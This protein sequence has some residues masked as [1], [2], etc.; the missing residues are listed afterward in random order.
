MY[1]EKHSNSNFRD[2]N[3]IYT[4]IRNGS[5]TPNFFPRSNTIDT[6]RTVSQSFD[7]SYSNS[8]AGGDNSGNFGEGAT[9][10]LD[11]T[12]FLLTFIYNDYSNNREDG[13]ACLGCDKSNSSSDFLLQLKDVGWATNNQYTI[14]VIQG[15]GLLANIT[16]IM[17][18]SYF[19]VT[20]P[21][22]VDIYTKERKLIRINPPSPDSYIRIVLRHQ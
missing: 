9:F 8:S 20:S 3:Y 18:S 13:G 5:I 7:S 2:T 15:T 17:D 10:R 14:G 22:N 16:S 19:A 12:K 4:N 11:T 6:D 21:K 1:V